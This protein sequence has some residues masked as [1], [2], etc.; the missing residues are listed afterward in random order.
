MSELNNPRCVLCKDR[1]AKPRESFGG[2]YLCDFCATFK[3]DKTDEKKAVLKEEEP[4]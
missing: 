3:P 2:I 1:G 4:Q